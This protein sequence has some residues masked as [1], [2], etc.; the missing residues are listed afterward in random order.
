MKSSAMILNWL[1]NW[2]KEFSRN[3]FGTVEFHFSSTFD[4]LKNKNRLKMMSQGL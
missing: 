1:K 4:W 2:N 3:G